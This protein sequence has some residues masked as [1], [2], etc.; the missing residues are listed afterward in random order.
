MTNPS[1]NIWIISKS[2]IG[3]SYLDSEIED[4]GYYYMD[5]SGS[6]VGNGPFKSLLLCKKAL[7]DYDKSL[8]GSEYRKL[9]YCL[10]F[11]DDNA[12]LI[13]W[14]DETE[15]PDKSIEIMT[16]RLIEAGWHKVGDK[17]VLGNPHKRYLFFRSQGKSAPPI[18][19][20]S[21]L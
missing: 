20:W 8:G 15:D 5:S 9:I 6:M 18:V 13:P 3:K 21:V 10:T 19:Q 2:D 14:S 4:P 11:H 17:L 1:P 12:E 16:E 7:N